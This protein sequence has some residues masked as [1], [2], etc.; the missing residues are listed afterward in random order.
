MA[1]WYY[2]SATLGDGGHTTIRPWSDDVPMEDEDGTLYAVATKV[3]ACAIWNLVDGGSGEQVPLLTLAE[4]LNF[5]RGRSQK[6]QERM[7]LIM[8]RV[9]LRARW[10]DKAG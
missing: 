1:P 9:L 7:R 4:W 5:L 6:D 10:M 3:P 2:M 8:V